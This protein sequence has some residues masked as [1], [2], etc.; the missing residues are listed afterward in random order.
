[1]LTLGPRSGAIL[2]GLILSLNAACFFKQSVYFLRGILTLQGNESGNMREGN[3]PD[4][5][6]GDSIDLDVINP[7]SI[8]HK[9]FFFL[10]INVNS[11]FVVVPCYA[12]QD[13][14]QREQG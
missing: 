5:S 14:S 1:M 4:P 7:H 10:V 12:G 11:M 13:I 9:L 2:Q 6:Y 3:T 8:P